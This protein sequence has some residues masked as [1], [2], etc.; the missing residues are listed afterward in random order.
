MLIRIDPTEPVPLLHPP[1]QTGFKLIEIKTES[2][3]NDV[4][5]CYNIRYVNEHKKRSIL[6]NFREDR[7]KL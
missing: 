6:S 5:S 3:E 2:T 7:S 1:S 4:A